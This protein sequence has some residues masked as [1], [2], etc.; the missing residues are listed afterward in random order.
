MFF[1]DY[2]I[3]RNIH[4]A[5]LDEAERPVISGNN[6]PAYHEITPHHHARGQLLHGVHGV[7]SVRTERGAW[8]APA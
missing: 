2:A 3:A 6:Y 1:R 4:G 8:V 5:E 7:M